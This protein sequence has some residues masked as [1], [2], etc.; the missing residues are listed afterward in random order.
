MNHEND[1]KTKRFLSISSEIAG[2]SAGMALG[3]VFGIPGAFAGTFFGSVITFLARDFAFRV[4]SHREHTRVVGVLDLAAAHV[5]AKLRQGYEP[6][7]DNF[8]NDVPGH[9][10][11]AEELVEGVLIAAQREHEERKLKYM[12]C[13]LGNFVFYEDVDLRQANYLV[14]LLSDLSWTQLRLLA[15][16]SRSDIEGLRSTSYMGDASDALDWDKLV[17]LTQVVELWFL[18]LISKQSV[19]R[20]GG[21][22]PGPTSVV[23][24]IMK[25]MHFGELLVLLA[26]LRSIDRT[27]LDEVADLL[28]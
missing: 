22:V 4:L 3:L 11:F 18:N 8:P 2:D 6:R 23:P 12:A 9:R 1:D 20:L 28:R 27:E 26:E 24:S 21:I 7:V 17:I 15:I 25:P 5:E 19:E 10:S 14:R 16:F 13:L